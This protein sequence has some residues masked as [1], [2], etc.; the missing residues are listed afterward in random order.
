MM[1]VAA[2]V[3]DGNILRLVQKFLRS[4][5]MENGVFKPTTVG[6]PQGGVIS[7]LLANIVLNH[8]DWQLYQHGYQCVR[9]ADD[10]VVIC[11][12][13]LQAESALNLLQQVLGTLGLQ[14][15]AA[16]TRISTFGKGYSFLGFVLSSR[17][18]QMRPKSLQKFKDKVRKLTLRHY[19]FEAQVI[20]KLNRVLKGTSHYFATSFATCRWLFQHLD[21]WIRMRL[22]CMKFKRKWATDNYKLRNRT[23]HKLGLFS[24]EQFCILQRTAKA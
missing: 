10:F 9:Y 20:E 2:E 17:S 19:N 5:V 15:S 24:M 7:P 18:R 3:A 6:T 23:F 13:K 22:R 4:G 1:A 21:C 8:L 16:K 14:L 11:R 12:S